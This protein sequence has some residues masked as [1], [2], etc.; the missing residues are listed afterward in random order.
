[1][2]N[3]LRSGL[4]RAYRAEVQR[5]LRPTGDLPPITEAEIAQLPAPVQRYLHYTG[6]VGRPRVRNFRTRFTGEMRFS[7]EEKWMSIGSQQ[8][9]FIDEPARFFYI[10]ASLHGVPFEGLH[11]YKGANASMQIRAAYF[12]RVADAR[13]PKMDQGETVTMFNDLCVYAPPALIDRNIQWETMGEL[14]VKAS[15]SNQEHSIT[16]VLE[17]NEKGELVDFFSDDRFYCRDGKTYLNC[18]WSTPVADYADIEG[19]KIPSYGEACWHAPEGKYSY[20]KFRLEE[21]D[22]NCTAFE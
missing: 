13:G 6:A 11:M 16:A 14:S 21:I 8:Y 15:F 19:R 20:A 4:E 12:F 5:L 9:N 18:R 22:Y 10:R 3:I 7:K 2:C 1:M 17:F